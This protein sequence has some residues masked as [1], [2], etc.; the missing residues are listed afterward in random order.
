MSNEQHK[1]EERIEGILKEVRE[2]TREEISEVVDSYLEDLQEDI[3]V[4]QEKNP[5]VDIAQFLPPLRSNLRVLIRKYQGKSGRQRTTYRSSDTRGETR[6][7][8]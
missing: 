2:E 7:D 5:D 3:E 4:V 8:G 1:P 6:A